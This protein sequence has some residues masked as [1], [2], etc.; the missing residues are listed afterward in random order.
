MRRAAPWLL[1]SLLVGHSAHADES[2]RLRYDFRE[3]SGTVATYRVVSE[4]RVAQSIQGSPD[5]EGAVQAKAGE[6]FSRIEETQEWEFKRAANGGRIKITTTDFVVFL[7]EEGHQVEYRS[8]QEG[9]VPPKLEP[10]VEKLGKPVTL[11]VSTRGQVTRVRGVSSKLRRGFQNTFVEL[12]HDPQKPGESWTTTDRQSMPP[13]GRLIFRF[14]YTLKGEEQG[15]FG[16]QRRIE[17]KVTATF[18]DETSPEEL[19]EVTLGKHEGNGHL[20]LDPRGLV[21]ESALD[22]TLEV[23][24][25]AP[26]GEQGQVIKNKSLQ[27]LTRVAQS[28]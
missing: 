23:R 18:D 13:L 16:T 10:L 14:A 17:A 12:P 25:A 11:E 20:L 3:L 19:I 6:V 27:V 24:V 28:D 21:I 1:V 7:E 22:S 4:Q 8:R 26:A 2:L 5:A 9:P 15:D